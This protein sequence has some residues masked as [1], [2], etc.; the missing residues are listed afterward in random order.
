MGENNSI[1]HSLWIGQSLSALELLTLHSFVRHGYNFCLWLYQPLT[2]V[3][4]EGVELMDANEIIP[5]DRIFK[6]KEDDPSFKVG[7]GS[8]GTFS[9]I[10]RYKLLYDKGGIW[11]DMDITCLKPYV[12]DNPYF[13]RKHHILDAMGN[14]I[15]CPIGSELM[16]SAYKESLVTCNADTQEWLMTNTILNKHIKRLGLQKYITSQLS[17]QD[18]WSAISNFIY[19]ECDI[20]DNWYFLHWMNEEWRRQ[21]LGK[22]KY[23][24]RTTLAA[25]LRQYPIIIE[26]E[27]SIFKKKKSQFK[28]SSLFKTLEHYLY[29]FM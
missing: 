7:K 20:P 15:K 2:N 3:L 4:P 17:N 28:S 8:Y 13:F 26:M 1:V 12:F 11:T 9:D 29:K 14:L 24:N 19:S 6:K 25:L 16:L 10:F 5:K 27:D 23:F 21:G 18:K 22:K